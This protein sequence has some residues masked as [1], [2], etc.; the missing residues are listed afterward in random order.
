VLLNQCLHELDLWHWLFGMPLRLRA[1]LG[2]GSSHRIEVEDR[3][4]AYLDL[5]GGATGVFVASSGEAPGTNRLEVVGDA[6]KL[7]IEGDRLEH[8][9]NARPAS[10]Y[11]RLELEGAPAF[12][13]TEQVFARAASLRREILQNFVAVLLDGAPLVAPAV[14]GLASVEL[15]N[16]MVASSLESRTVTLPLDGEDYAS[17]LDRLRTSSGVV[18]AAAHFTQNTVNASPPSSG[19]AGRTFST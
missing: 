10:E 11:A 6:G 5:P 17:L 13:R 19:V 3:A 12:T 16:A 14:E 15:A 4:T 2:F 1:F 18:A 8:W 9:Q 7:V